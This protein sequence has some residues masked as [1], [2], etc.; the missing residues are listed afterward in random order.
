VG[1]LRVMRERHARATDALD[2]LGADSDSAHASAA[3]IVVTTTVSVYPTSAAQFYACNPQIITGSETEGASPTYTTD[4]AT[5]IYALNVGTQI[6]P[7]GTEL[8]V[9][10]VGGRWVFRY[11]G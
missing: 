1:D 3:L 2:Q 11:D 8:V 7:N 4:T 10:S 5:T 9:H 6:P